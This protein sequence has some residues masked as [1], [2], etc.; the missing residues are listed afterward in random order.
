[1]NSSFLMD[2]NS[3]QAKTMSSPRGDQAEPEL[4][5]GLEFDVLLAEEVIAPAAISPLPVN[6]VELSLATTQPPLQNTGVVFLGGEG[7]RFPDNVT[8][9]S[10]KFADQVGQASKD[11]MKISDA[12]IEAA[13]RKSLL[14]S[15]DLTPTMG[16]KSEYQA[17]QSAVLLESGSTQ[18]Q[19]IIVHA[20][21]SKEPQPLSNARPVDTTP[22]KIQAATKKEQVDL[23]VQPSWPGSV[24][25]VATA[26]QVPDKTGPALKVGEQ[27]PAIEPVNTESAVSVPLKTTIHPKGQTP[28]EFTAPKLQI[29]GSA[30]EVPGTPDEQEPINTSFP[31]GKSSPKSTAV[32]GQ[33]TL[34]NT[35]YAVLQRRIESGVGVPATDIPPLSGSR[36]VSGINEFQRLP[37]SPSQ[38][39]SI[40]FQG[41][42]PSVITRQVGLLPAEQDVDHRSIALDKAQT[43]GRT[44]GLETSSPDRREPAPNPAQGS[45]IKIQLGQGIGGITPNPPGQIEQNDTLSET[46]L[47][48][49]PLLG[50][51]HPAQIQ[52]THPSPIISVAQNDHGMRAVQAITQAAHALQD[53]P[54]EL[55]LNPEEL[56][57]V[58][59]TLHHGDGSMSVSIA[60]ERPETM[61]LLRR[62]IDLLADQLRD[63]GYRDL[64]FDFTG[65]NNEDTAPNDEEPHGEFMEQISAAS[66]SP[67]PRH[68]SV[69]LIIDPNAAIDIRL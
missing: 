17:V 6:Q 44:S 33:T 15:Q 54:V 63:I 19:T 10:E 69:S 43:F 27:N 14:P 68:G 46:V 48:D 20:D 8:A 65:N 53:H 31:D 58:K 5:D 64:A 9:D 16:Q 24:P 45:I 59:L 50:C 56:G 67:L 26:T 30:V 60:A 34:N 61:D 11:F 4:H 7:D 38:Q 1:M 35:G 13:T 22:P 66:D 23:G 57:R 3:G 55:L 25:I 37:A 42:D 62:H 52:S 12:D 36:P 29:I 28:K 2:I 40:V 21:Q 51:D 41:R 47:S 49:V 18:A 39:T 32:L